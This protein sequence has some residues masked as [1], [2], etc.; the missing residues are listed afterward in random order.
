M[1]TEF[2]ERM[3]AFLRQQM[4]DDE[5]ESAI[6]KHFQS[7]PP[8]VLRDSYRNHLYIERSHTDVQ[9]DILE[10]IIS[11]YANID[12][13]AAIHPQGSI[14][15]EN[16]LAES[17]RG[18]SVRMHNNLIEFQKKQNPNLAKELKKV[19]AQTTLSTL[20]GILATRASYNSLLPF[21]TYTTAAIGTEVFNHYTSRGKKSTLVLRVK[22]LAQELGIEEPATDFDHFYT[23]L[24]LFY[25]GKGTSVPS[26]W[27]DLIN[28]HDETFTSQIGN[29]VI[30]YPA[31]E[32]LQSQVYAQRELLRKIHYKDILRYMVSTHSPEPRPRTRPIHSN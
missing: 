16:I 23:R 25:E 3:R 7:I 18:N 13:I 19:E 1:L 6:K 30:H 32:I 17:Q 2:T 24:Q 4:S 29:E 10:G 31:K 12:T 20:G 27:E 5:I 22:S 21:A 15:I 14:N 28:H 11:P 8:E 26:I 9:P